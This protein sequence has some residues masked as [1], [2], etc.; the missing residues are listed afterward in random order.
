MIQNDCKDIIAAQNGDNDIMQKLLDQNKGLIWSIVK[1]F[2]DRGH[3]LEDL[4]QIACMAFIK[5][6]KRFDVNY[7][8]KLSTYAVPY[9]L[10]EIKRF[11][12]DDGPIKVSRSAKEL[13]MKIYELQKMNVMQTGK[14]L[15]VNEIAKKL[16]VPKEDVVFALTSGKPLESIDE[17]AYDDDSKTKIVDQLTDDKDEANTVINNLALKQM[18]SKL[19]DREKEIILLRFFKDQTQTQVAKVIGVTQVQVSRIEK[20]I[21]SDMRKGMIG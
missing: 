7:D 11:V 14:E 21:L 9:I 8:V 2:K 3:D 15:T 16:E 6:I 1:R 4:Y 5:A 13:L 19:N 18:L 12:R 20:K 17:Y 10:G